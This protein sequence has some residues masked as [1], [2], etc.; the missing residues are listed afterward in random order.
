MFSDEENK[1]RRESCIAELTEIIKHFDS[2]KKSDRKRQDW[3]R[4]F[5]CAESAFSNSSLHCGDVA[6]AIKIATGDI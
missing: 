3:I 5:R 1:E 6:Q 2:I 4:L